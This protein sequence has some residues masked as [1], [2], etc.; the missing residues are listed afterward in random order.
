MGFSQANKQA[1][2][3]TNCLEKKLQNIQGE[4]FHLRQSIQKLQQ[5]YLA[6][7]RTL[8]NR[9]QLD[10]IYKLSRIQMERTKNGKY[11]HEFK[12]DGETMKRLAIGLI[13][14]PKKRIK[15]TWRGNI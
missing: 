6:L 15:R 10:R 1:P 2:L 12:R 11:D 14:I 13:I 7:L 3:K 9:K 4:K 8:C 5:K